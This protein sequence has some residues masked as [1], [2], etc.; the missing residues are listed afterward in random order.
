MES[1][2]D[3]VCR[4]HWQL[5]AD[6][7]CLSC[8]AR[9][10]RACVKVIGSASGAICSVCGELCLPFAEVKRQRLRIAD[11]QT[12]FGPGDFRF[13]LA[14]P[15]KE[16]LTL[17]GLGIVSGLGLFSLP[18]FSL[19]KVG[20]LLGSIGLIPMLLSSSLMFGCAWQIIKCLETGRSDSDDLF[21]VVALFADILRVVRVSLAILLAIALPLVFGLQVGIQSAGFRY[22]SIGWMIF[23][24]PIALLVAAI[25]QSFWSTLN[26]LV[27]L[28]AIHK[29]GRDYFKLLAKYLA[30]IVVTSMVI[31]GLG[32]S[33]LPASFNLLTLIIFLLVGMVLAP[34]L[35]YANMVLASLLGRLLLKCGERI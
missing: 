24:Y 16:P 15:L 12:P 35:F 9:C 21:D 4:N 31:W 26:P 3:E 18:F 22:L 28:N 8:E 20:V 33:L 2:K 6:F 23:Y 34:P 13:A 5:P 30:V 17:L 29:L 10:C 32:I 7:I 25:S 14:Y 27:G 11:R 19:L 1:D